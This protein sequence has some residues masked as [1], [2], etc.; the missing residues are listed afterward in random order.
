MIRAVAASLLSAALLTGCFVDELLG[1]SAADSGSGRDSGE[2]EGQDSGERQ[3]LVSPACQPCG[4]SGPCVGE[5][6]DAGCRGRV[7]TGG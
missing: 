4:D 6:A 5:Q 2:P 7:Y 1:T 3:D